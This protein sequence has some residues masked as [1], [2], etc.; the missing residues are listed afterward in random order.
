[1]TRVVVML[2]REQDASAWRE[3]F[4]RGETMDQ[5]PYGY[6]RAE[7]RYDMRWSESRPDGV[8]LGRLRRLLVRQF[9]FD[10]V[11]AMQ[12]RAL[13]R[14]ADVIWTHTEREHLAVALIRRIC[15]IHAPVIAQSVWLWDVWEDLSRPRR[16]LY[17]RLLTSQAIEIVHSPVNAEISR[18]TIPNRAVHLVPFGS[19][20]VSRGQAASSVSEAMVL[21]VGNDVDRDWDTLAAAL[22]EAPGLSARIVSSRRAAREAAWSDNVVVAPAGRHELERL[23]RSASVVVVPV[24]RNCHASG[25]TAC[26]EALAAHRALVAT[27]T[28]GLA[29]YVGGAASLVPVGDP[30][31]LAEAIRS[32]IH[33]GGPQGDPWR[34]RGLTQADYVARYVLITEW[35]LG[36][37]PFPDVVSEFRPV[38]SALR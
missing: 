21:A 31:S 11:H 24:R 14:S 8:M 23:Y 5:T 15:R 28:G 37:R 27:D 13:L 34:E 35:L 33:E 2:N 9:G 26:I 18:R 19:A 1:M 36:R 6:D 3:R 17:Q 20:P 29:A 30:Q 38:R 32:A 22:R 10:V 25:A 12:N 4:R 7:V 16:M